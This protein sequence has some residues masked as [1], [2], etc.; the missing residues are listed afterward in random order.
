MRT[1]DDLRILQALP[2]DLK[3]KKSLL[4]IREWYNHWHGK[5]YVSFSGGKDSTVLL[6]LVRSIY[7]EEYIS[8]SSSSFLRHRIG[9]SRSQKTR[10]SFSECYSIKTAI[11]FSASDRKIW[12]GISEQRCSTQ[13][14]LCKARK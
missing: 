6:H 8:G 7:P 14:L 9:I 11:K 1:I 2:L 12:L 10:F 5:V 4:R 3:I 13:Y